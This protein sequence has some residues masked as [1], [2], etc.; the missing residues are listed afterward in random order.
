MQSWGGT[1]TGSADSRTLTFTCNFAAPAFSVVTLRRGPKVLQ[2]G[3]IATCSGQTGLV[4]LA[5]GLQPEAGDEM[6]LESIPAPPPVPPYQ[7]QTSQIHSTSAQADPT[8]QRWLRQGFTLGGWCGGSRSYS[9]SY[10]Y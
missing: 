5:G 4:V 9:R 6:L 2:L 1:V 8:Y 7:P 10:R 3:E